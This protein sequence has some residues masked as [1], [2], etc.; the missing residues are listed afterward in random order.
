MKS[1]IVKFTKSNVT[2]LMSKENYS[3]LL[4]DLNNLKDAM[5]DVEETFDFRLSDIHNMNNLQGNLWRFLGY[6][7]RDTHWDD[8][9][10]PSKAP[11]VDA[12]TG[13]EKKE[14]S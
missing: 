14:A 11:V 13:A 1:T 3:E 7:N 6:E 9:K 4:S 12:F 10:L 2:I 5:N 8:Y